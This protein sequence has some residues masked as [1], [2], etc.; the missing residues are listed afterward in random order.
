MSPDCIEIPDTL[1]GDTAQRVYCAAIYYFVVSKIIINLGALNKRL[2][3]F[4]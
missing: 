4:V 3:L 1:L 2:S